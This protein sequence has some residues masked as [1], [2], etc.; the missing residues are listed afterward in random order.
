[1]GERWKLETHCM[2]NV[3]PRGLVAAVSNR[4]FETLCI[5]AVGFE[6]IPAL[7]TTQNQSK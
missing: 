2:P 3:N 7:A 6:R 4:V 1:M 5:M